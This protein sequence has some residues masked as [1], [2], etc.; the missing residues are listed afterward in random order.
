MKPKILILTPVYNDWEN[1]IKLLNKINKIFIKEIKLMCS[2]PPRSEAYS[3]PYSRQSK[4]PYL[5]ASF[6]RLPRAG[7][8]LYHPGLYPPHPRQIQN[9]RQ[10]QGLKPP[11]CHQKRARSTNGRTDRNIQ[12]CLRRPSHSCRQT[13]TS[14][15]HHFCP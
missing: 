13:L 7:I 8:F 5:G 14:R 4:I 10:L 12:N 2:V 6:S 15:F 3:S 1:L 11:A 9:M